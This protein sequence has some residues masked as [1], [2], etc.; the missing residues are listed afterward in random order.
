MPQNY[1]SIY[2]K[3]SVDS[4][5]FQYNVHSLISLI[6]GL[7]SIFTIQCY[8]TKSMASYKVKFYINTKTIGIV[9]NE[10]GFFI[11]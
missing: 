7:F 6:F 5:I 9:D 2:S 1:D 11:G 4:Y 8:T 10:C 3:E